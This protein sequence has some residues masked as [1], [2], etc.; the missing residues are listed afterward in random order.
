MTSFEYDG[1][2][3]LVRAVTVRESEFSP[4]ESALLLASREID[5][6][7]KN[8][9][10][11]PLSESMDPANQF[12]YVPPK[13]PTIDYQEQSL[14]RA[15]DTHYSQFGKDGNGNQLPRHGHHWRAPTLNRGS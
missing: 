10:G 13:A 15:Q 7:P 1:E 12:A 11:T 2:G 3:R 4:Q 8:S 14:G 6:E 5:A 9:L